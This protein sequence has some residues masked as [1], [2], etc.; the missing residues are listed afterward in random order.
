VLLGN[1]HGIEVDITE[2]AKDLLPNVLKKYDV[3]LLNNAN[4]LGDLIPKEQQEAVQAWF[5]TGKGMVG[6]HAALVKQDS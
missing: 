2:H 1:E 6:I 3:L 5:A 4:Q